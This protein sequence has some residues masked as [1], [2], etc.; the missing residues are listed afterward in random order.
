MFWAEWE[1]PSEVID[2]IRAPLP[3]K[4]GFVYRPYWVHP[5]SFRGLQNTDPF[6]FGGFYYGICR[7][8]RST[9][10][11]QLQRLLPGSV[12]LFGSHLGGEFVLDTV[13]VVRRGIDHTD[14]DFRLVLRG[15]AP[16]DYI[17]TALAPFYENRDADG[18]GSGTSLR[19]Y[20]GATV[21]DPLED[22]YSFFP[23]QECKPGSRGFARPR[24][25]LPGIVN[26]RAKQA[27]PLNRGLEPAR[28]PGLW[29]EVREQVL[30]QGCALGVEA[31]FPERRQNHRDS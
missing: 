27:G 16:E 6:V 21:K 23:C 2:E 9:G 3:G 28:F 29:R 26:P 20:L 22:M 5:G 8:N 10:P 31:E 17:T 4:P 15:E 19:L 18:C 11:T 1:P 14:R 24:I 13:F 7:Q 30:G 12:I 25:R